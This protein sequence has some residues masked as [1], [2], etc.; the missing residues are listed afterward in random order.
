M[1]STLRC[2]GN[3]DANEKLNGLRSLDREEYIC[4]RSIDTLE[5][6]IK[7]KLML[8]QCIIKEKLFHIFF[9]YSDSD[10]NTEGEKWQNI[11]NR[12]ISQFWE[13]SEIRENNRK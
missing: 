7:L 11:H 2:C 9:T 1:T 13:R 3:A 8:M 10:A 12:K 4:N 5:R 6:T